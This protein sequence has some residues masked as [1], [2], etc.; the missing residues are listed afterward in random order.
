MMLRKLLSILLLC[1][2]LQARVVHVP[3]TEA[4][5][6]QTGINRA[7]LNDTV[8]VADGVYTGTGNYNIDLKRRSVLMSEHGPEYTIIDCQGSSSDRRRAFL[9]WRGED[10]STVVEGFTIRGGYAP[11]DFEDQYHDLYSA[12]GA[13]SFLNNSSPVIRNCTFTLNHADRCGGAV[14]CAGSSPSFVDCL[15]EA[16][17]ADWEGGAVCACEGSN[18]EFSGTSFLLNTAF[19]GGGVFTSGTG[20]IFTDCIM[21]QNMCNGGGGVGSDRDFER[22]S[23]RLCRF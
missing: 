14:L 23:C 6:I 9:F 17:D 5:T 12:G 19:E 20:A 8:L 2:V 1:P 10:S 22:L 16:N 21:S 3:S 4:P 15:F 7:I 11:A 18:P 13:I